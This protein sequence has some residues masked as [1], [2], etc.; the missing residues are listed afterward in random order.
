LPDVAEKE[1]MKSLVGTYG[2]PRHAWQIARVDKL[3]RGIPQL[4]MGFT[5]DEQ[6]EPKM[7]EGRDKSYGISSQKKKA[8]EGTERSILTFTETSYVPRL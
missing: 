1:L 6:A 7:V 8:P 5:A 2:K 3:P 4:M